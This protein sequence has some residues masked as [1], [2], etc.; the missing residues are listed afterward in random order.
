ML[1]WGLQLNLGG[2]LVGLQ[3]PLEASARL[4]L[5]LQLHESTQLCPCCLASDTIVPLVGLQIAL[6]HI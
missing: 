2:F 6:P 4:A 3:T 1:T 5:H